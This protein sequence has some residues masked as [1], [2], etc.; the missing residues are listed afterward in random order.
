MK[1][2]KKQ[3]KVIDISKFEKKLTSVET[4]IQKQLLAKCP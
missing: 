4:A 2:R 3:I 1:S